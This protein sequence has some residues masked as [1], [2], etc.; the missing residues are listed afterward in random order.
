MR[1]GQAYL[2]NSD[3]DVKYKGNDEELYLTSICVCDERATG[4]Y[5]VFLDVLRDCPIAT[6]ITTVGGFSRTNT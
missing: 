1:A 6:L 2:V 4:L 3:V 5:I